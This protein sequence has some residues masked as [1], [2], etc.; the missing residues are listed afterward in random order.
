M[1]TLILL[2][3]AVSCYGQQDWISSTSAR[4]LLGVPICSGAPTNNYYLKY[5]SAAGCAGWAAGSSVS[6]TATQFGYFSD[7]STLASSPGLLTEQAGMTYTADGP[8]LAL[9]GAGAYWKRIGAGPPSDAFTIDFKGTTAVQQLVRFI[10]SGSNVFQLASFGTGWVMSGLTAISFLTNQVSMTEGSE[11]MPDGT[12]CT[13]TAAACT[14]NKQ[15]GVITTEALTT[16]AASSYTMTLTNSLITASSIVQATV[17]NGT[18]S[19]GQPL[20]GRIT[21]GSGSATIQIFNAHASAAFNGTIKISFV[22][23][24]PQ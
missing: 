21:P 12:T 22:V 1:R 10:D 20:V 4:R 3:C 5:T 8:I 6:G 11:F 2:I 18:N 24:N 15:S 9:N 23:Y 14:V 19:A 13:S 7:S 17:W 16:A